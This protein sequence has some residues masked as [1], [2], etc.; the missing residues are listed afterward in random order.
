MSA[1]GVPLVV[2]VVLNWNRR[3]ETLACLDALARSTHPALQVVVVDNGSEDGT[4]DAVA[5]AHPRV[6]VVRSEVNLGFAGGNNLGLARARALGAEQVLVLNN[7]VEVEPD[8]VATLAAAAQRLPRAGAL[9]PKILFADPPGHIWFAGASFDPRRGYNGRQRGYGRPDG[10]ELDGL[11]ETGRSCGAAMLVPRAALDLVGD[12][13]EEL[14]LYSEDTDWSLRALAAGLRLYVVAEARVTHLVSASAGG[15]SSP[16]TLYYGM[17]NTL[18][19][20]ERHAPL[21]RVGTHRRRIVMLGA[22]LLQALLSPRR[23]DGVR[24]VLAGWRDG[25]AGRLG[26]RPAGEAS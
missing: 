22:H 6:D 26:P 24:A 1:A 20:C 17:R 21:G 4:A 13:D 9:N 11:W 2:A 8:T 19:V 16:A 15:E 10:P 18:V 12:F 7:D 3:E 14:F 25:R 5:A 23:R